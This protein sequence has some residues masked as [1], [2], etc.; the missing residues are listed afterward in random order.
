M[1]APHQ[2]SG[3]S[4]R[5]SSRSLVPMRRLNTINESRGGAEQPA[6][7]SAD[8]DTGGPGNRRSS[9]LR[10]RRAPVPAPRRSTSDQRDS[11]EHTEDR[12]E[13]ACPPQ[14]PPPRVWVPEHLDPNEDGA[15]NPLLRPSSLGSLGDRS[16]QRGQD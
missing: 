15:G 5:S 14:L 9:S 1:S 16:G 4:P 10:S 2:F 13:P 11:C 7:V 3:V 8:G 6:A 12:V